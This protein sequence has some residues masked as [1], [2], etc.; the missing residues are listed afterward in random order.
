M[1]TS[2][3]NGNGN[4]NS[5]DMTVTGCNHPHTRVV[6]SRHSPSDQPLQV[7]RMRE[8]LDCH[9]KLPTREVIDNT[10]GSDLKYYNKVRLSN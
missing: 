8:C 4:G 10:A 7:V 9:Q 1:G 5:P 6:D 2:N 3:G